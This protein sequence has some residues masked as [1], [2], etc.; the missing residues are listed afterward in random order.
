MV[1]STLTGFLFLVTFFIGRDAMRK[2]LTYEC[3]A[4]TMWALGFLAVGRLWHS[5]LEVLQLKTIW[6]NWPEIAEYGVYVLGFLIFARL[7]WKGYHIR[8]PERA[9]KSRS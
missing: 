5:I 6:G 7:M 8:T 1:L 4:A 9:F 3:L 2:G